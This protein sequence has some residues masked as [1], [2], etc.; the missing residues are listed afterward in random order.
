[1]ATQPRPLDVV[2]ATFTS[3]K[4]MTYPELF[5]GFDTLKAIT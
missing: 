3:N 5:E 2:Q 1:M 4:P